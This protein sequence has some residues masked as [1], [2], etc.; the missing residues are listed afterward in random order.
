VDA[1]GIEQAAFRLPVGTVTFMLTDVEGSTWLWE[2]AHEAASAAV[3]R[4][5][6][7]LDEAVALHGGVRPL[8]QDEG[9]GAVAAF[10]RASD[11]LAA[12]LDVQRAFHSEGWPEGASLK[13]RIALHTAEWCCLA[14]RATWP[15]IG[16]PSWLSW[17]TLVSI[18]CVISG[19]PSTSLGWCTQICR[20]SFRHCAHWTRCPTICPVS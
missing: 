3:A 7:L 4:H 12:A 19:G 13:L 18:G 17:L 11:A 20:R 15:W 1:D 2:C 14:R 5:D 10:T 6:E 16:F 9:D 8:E